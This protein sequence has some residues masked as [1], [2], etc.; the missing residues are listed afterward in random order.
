M[1]VTTLIAIGSTV[2]EN[3]KDWSW[4]WLDSAKIPH[5]GAWTLFNISDVFH[6]IKCHIRKKK[7]LYTE[8]RK[9][10][11]VLRDRWD[12]LVVSSKFAR[13]NGVKMVLVFILIT[14]LSFG[15]M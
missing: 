8:D 15:A 2:V 3:I 5:E 11:K 1:H 4:T 10:E 7:N 9:E 6:W 13:I 14:T 12:V